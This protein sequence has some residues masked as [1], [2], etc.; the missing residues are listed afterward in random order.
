MGGIAL[1]K[2]KNVEGFTANCCYGNQQQHLKAL[3]D[4]IDANSYCFF[5]KKDLVFK[6]TYLD[7]FWVFFCAI[8]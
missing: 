5:T 4:S 6:Q 1:I 3:F 7:A 2:R 8:N